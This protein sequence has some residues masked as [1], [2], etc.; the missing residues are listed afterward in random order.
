MEF[1]VLGPLEVAQLDCL[2]ELGPPKQRLVAGAASADPAAA[3]RRLRQALALWRGLPLAD[4]AYE[5][6]AQSQIARLE[7][8]RLLPES[9][10]LVLCAFRD[11][12]PALGEPLL[13]TLA[14]LVREPRTLQVA[15]AGLGTGDIAEYIERSTGVVP[16]RRLRPGERVHRWSAEASY[17]LRLLE[18]PAR[19]T[20]G[21]VT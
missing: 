2:L 8:L 18:A 11:V 1:R 3:A 10:V 6:F 9:R 7:E 19:G 5:P 16:R 12:D 14:E 21:L 20:S 17:R 4:L 13:A 15:P